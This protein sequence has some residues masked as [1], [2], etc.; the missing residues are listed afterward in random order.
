MATQGISEMRALEH[1]PTFKKK[2]IV[3]LRKLNW[4]SLLHYT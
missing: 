2:W 4:L 1:R 3:S